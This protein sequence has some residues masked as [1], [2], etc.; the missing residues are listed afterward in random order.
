MS[1]LILKR[2]KVIHDNSVN[3]NFLINGNFDVWQRGSS[4]YN[5]S[6]SA[7]RWYFASYG[8][9]QAQ[10]LLGNIGLSDTQ[11]CIRLQ[12]LGNDSFASITQVVPTVLTS[13]LRN[14][15]VTLS[16]YARSPS[17]NFTNNWSGPIYGEVFF[18]SEVDDITTGRILIEDSLFSGTLT[19]TNDWQFYSK[20]FSVPSNA[21][22]LSVVIRPSGNLSDSSVV[23]IA[24]VKLEQ[25]SLATPIRS[26]FGGNTLYTCKTFYQTVNATLKAGTA[27]SANAKK[28]FGY[29][30]TLP[31]NPRTSNP[32]ITIADSSTALSNLTATISNDNYL[33][34]TAEANSPHSQLSSV[35]TIDNELPVG[36]APG[37][38]DYIDINRV[39][40]TIY[41]DWN[42][43]LYTTENI[44]DYVVYYGTTPN[45]L[46]NI[47][48][49][50]DS[51]GTLTGL[52]DYSPY[53]L[54]MQ[55]I[56]PF[57]ESELSNLF[58]SAPIYTAPSAVLSPTGI[59]GNNIS[60]ISWGIPQNDG[61]SAITGYRIDRSMYSNFSAGVYTSS[62]Y[63]PMLPTSFNIA[64]FSDE[65]TTTGTYYFRIAAMNLAGT[66]TPSVIE[67]PKTVPYAPTNLQTSV[68][69]TQTVVLNYGPPTGNGG[70]NI[71]QFQL[72]RS[73]SS[74]FSSATNVSV[75]A[76]YQP[77]TVSGLTNGTTYYFRLRALNA[78]GYGSY[79]QT[80]SAV[81]FRTPTV[82]G[83]ISGLSASWVDNDTVS[84]SWLAPA[85]NG[86]VPINN[87]T[88]Y[89][90]TGSNFAT[91][92]LSPINTTN[93]TTAI[94]FDVP[95]TGSNSTFYFRG[96]ANNSVGSSASYSSSVSL[97]KQA[98]SSP[99]IYQASKGDATIYL[100]W[101]A[102]AS[103]KGSAITGYEVNYATNDS[104]GSSTTLSTTGLFLAVGSLTNGTY[105]YFRVRALN[106][107]GA[108][109]FSYTVFQAPVDPKQP[110]TNPYIYN[111]ALSP[112]GAG[113]SYTALVLSPNRASLATSPAFTTPY[114]L[115]E[116]P[117]TV[118]Y[119][120]GTIYGTTHYSYD[121]DIRTAAIHAGVLGP[122]ETGIVYLQTVGNLS[123]YGSVTQNGITST[124]RGTN[125]TPLSYQFIGS[126]I[127]CS[128]F[129]NAR[130]PAFKS[131]AGYV[132]GAPGNAGGSPVTGYELQ[133]STDLYFS[134]NTV[135]FSAA[136]NTTVASYCGA[137]SGNRI[138]ARL[139]AANTGGFSTWS[140]THAIYNITSPSVPSF[141]L[142]NL[143]NTGIQVVWSG[144]LTTLDR[145]YDNIANMSYVLYVNQSGYPFTSI[146]TASFTGVGASLTGQFAVGPGKYRCSLISK[147]YIY[148]SPGTNK[149][150]TVPVSESIGTG[151][152]LGLVWKLTA[153]SQ[154]CGSS[155]TTATINGKV[156][157]YPSVPALKDNNKNTTYS[158][159]RLGSAP[160][161]IQADFGS[162]VNVNKVII[163]AHWA[164]NPVS[165][166]NPHSLQASV[167]GNT[168]TTLGTIYN[169]FFFSKLN[170]VKSYTLPAHNGYRYIRILGNPSRTYMDLSEFY[171]E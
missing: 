111:G 24:K 48:S 29:S 47:L 40:G 70:V 49:I 115:V 16:F 74:S 86:G 66:G 19:G 96:K 33:N 149:Y 20:S 32:K 37:K 150:V 156:V 58:E 107:V 93:A 31:V 166:L 90:S 162:K 130:L 65:L 35:V 26:E 142:S 75:T 146:G 36:R 102:P 154:C 50:V 5:T 101:L 97:A 39:S 71:S 87:Y 118:P 170:Q 63:V 122:S 164:Y 80:V 137:L 17:G 114:R 85:D 140:P 144:G 95:I 3:D 69:V 169:L 84:V 121:S 56:N 7:D 73:T 124:Y 163:G 81:P 10:R 123:Y 157:Y 120:G 45:N 147:N 12:T 41:L 79:S 151:P 167:D 133:L 159:Y 91:N 171:F 76:N 132:W 143:S 25:G 82:P 42:T 52:L 6:Y 112:L 148:G 30:T 131:G 138:Y 134:Q 83:S 88:I 18:A 14:K 113:P 106:A 27:G 104:F 116:A 89:S 103:F 22:T 141:T 55:S 1:S 61:G 51:T 68:G 125:T 129:F 139:R 8:S 155:Y 128:G 53:Y 77:I 117:I 126:N 38:I 100:S 109:S 2:A 92:L 28:Q 110:P 23:D 60:Y 153:S 43:P 78:K 54:K 152:K 108:S 165:Y 98:P 160:Y 11:N 99:Q 105:Y 72:Q 46:N 15:T 62:H 57:G 161:F 21:S 4:F 64:K 145:G 44:V 59:W 34:L 67:V 136:G 158:A 135:T 9:N 13:E 94:S 119:S 127:K 168:W